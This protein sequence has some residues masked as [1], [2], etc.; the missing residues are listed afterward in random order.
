MVKKWGSTKKF[1]VYMYS[2]GYSTSKGYSKLMCTDT[3]GNTY[4]SS[5]FNLYKSKTGRYTSDN[6]V[7]DFSNVANIN[8]WYENSNLTT[9]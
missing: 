1:Y 6:C 7:K 3:R 5:N 4:N 9:T 2:P 8:S